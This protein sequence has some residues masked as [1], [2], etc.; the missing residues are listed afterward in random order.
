MK[1]DTS[2]ATDIMQFNSVLPFEST[3][4]GERPG[5]S[6]PSMLATEAQ[7]DV[8][9]SGGDPGSV[10]LDAAKALSVDGARGDWAHTGTA[11]DNLTDASDNKIRDVLGSD[12]QYRPFPKSVSLSGDHAADRM[13]RMTG[14]GADE[15]VM[16]PQD[17]S[18]DAGPIMSVTEL[19]A[20]RDPTMSAFFDLGDPQVS[21][22]STASEGDER[23]DAT[24]PQRFQRVPRVGTIEGLSSIKP[25]SMALRRELEEVRAQGRVTNSPR[26]NERPTASR[27]AEQMSNPRTKKMENRN[28]SHA[29]RGLNLDERVSTRS[30][31]GKAAERLL[32][33]ME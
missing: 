9:F 11:I 25:K 20:Q 32:E 7:L 6:V 3:I 10:G 8:V 13:A 23:Y 18:G 28:P 21:V 4:G 27:S 17:V 29:V 12:V 31:R 33:T 14:G 2:Y 16:E 26:L 30:T 22:Q 24:T 5:S 1:D 19:F 15:P